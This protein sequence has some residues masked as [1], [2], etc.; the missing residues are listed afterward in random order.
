MI[1]FIESQF[2]YCPLVWMFHSKTLHNKINRIHERSLRIVYNDDTS[3]FEELL[4]KDSSVSI[5]HRNVRA[6]AI[7]MYKAKNNLSPQIVQNLF[8]I[9]K[10][11]PNTRTQHDFVL[12]RSNTVHYGMESFQVYGTQN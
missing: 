3:S 9:R 2:S 11:L 6:L 7:E 12:P 8:Q 5:H 1:A 10:N 4:R